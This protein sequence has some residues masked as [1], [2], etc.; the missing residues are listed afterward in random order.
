MLSSSCLLSFVPVQTSF[1]LLNNKNVAGGSTNLYT[2]PGNCSGSYSV[3]SNCKARVFKF[4]FKSMLP[5]ATIFCTV[6]FGTS[7]ILTPIF[8]I[9]FI[10]CCITSLTCP[11][12]FVPVH[13]KFP[14]EKTKTAD[15]GSFILKTSP[16]NCSGLYSVLFC[17]LAN[18]VKETGLPR[19]VVATI[20][21]IFRLDFSAILKLVILYKG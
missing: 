2:S 9:C 16:G 18:L 7:V 21:C 17:V 5:E 4:K 3:F 11:T 12:L 14:E 8:P 19:D 10:T 20:F 15:F 1:P 6:I 13:T